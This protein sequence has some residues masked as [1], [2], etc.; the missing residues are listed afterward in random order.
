LAAWQRC[1]TTAGFRLDHFREG[2]TV[3]RVVSRDDAGNQDERETTEEVKAL[4]L[5]EWVGRHPRMSL[6]SF[7]T[8]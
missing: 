8:G 1:S 7:E 5:L 6:V 4:A 2:A 3:A